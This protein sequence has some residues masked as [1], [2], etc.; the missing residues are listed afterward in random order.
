MDISQMTILD[1]HL[2]KGWYNM[3]ESGVKPEE[4]REDKP[5]WCKR[6]LNSDGTFK[7]YTHV[8]F[9]YGYTKRTMLWK[10]KGLKIGR[11]NPDWGASEDKDMFIIQL[12]QR[13]Y[14]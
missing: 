9:H 14:E 3:I 6:L 5:Y 7:D 13:V 4:Y 11:G 10:I 12:G 1:L 8:R 2:K